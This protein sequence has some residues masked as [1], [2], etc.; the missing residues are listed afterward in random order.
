MVA[1]VSIL[2]VARHKQVSAFFPLLLCIYPIFETIFS[3]YRRKIIRKSSA[4][5]A[6]A[7]HLHTLLH[8]RIIPHVI[9]PK[10]KKDLLYKNSATSPILWFL[11]TI[12]A[13]PAVLFWGSRDILIAF[14]ILFMIIYVVVYKSIVGFKFIRAINFIVN[15]KKI[16]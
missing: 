4:S 10:S 14:T 3:M 12:S 6:D 9:D 1:E 16:R 8:R 7:L 5:K 15:W 11:T 13:V 2:L